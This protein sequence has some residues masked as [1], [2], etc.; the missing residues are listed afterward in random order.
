MFT[1]S[2]IFKGRVKPG[3]EAEFYSAVKERLV[4]AWT[5]MLHAVEVRVYRPCEAEPPGADVFLVQEIDYPSLA[6]LEEALVSSRREAAVE[7]L[8]SVQHLY[9]GQHHHIIYERL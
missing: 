5:Q 9:E 8:E 1:R 2:A 7:A 4:P 6:H 3:H